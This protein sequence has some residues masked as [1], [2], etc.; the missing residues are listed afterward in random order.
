MHPSPRPVPASSTRARAGTLL[1]AVLTAG[2]L[3]AGCSSST[4][5][6]A[7]SSAGGS[8]G[9][10]PAA[11]SDGSSAAAGQLDANGCITN[12]DPTVDYYPDKSEITYATN[13]TIDYHNSYQVLTV[14]QPTQG[15][16]PVSYVLVR[17]GA[18]TPDLTGELAGDTVVTTPV[19]SLY[20]GSTSHLGSLAALDSLDV[21]TGV[22]SKSL[23]SEKQVLDRVAEPGV[24]EYAAA[25]TVDAEAVVA[26]KPQVVITAGT[27]DP[28]YAA[29]QAAG[30]PV[31]ADAEWLESDPLG[32]AEWVKYFA[33]LTGKEAAAATFFDGVTEAYNALADK[34]SSA[35][36][37]QVV[38]GQPYQGTWFVPG[39]ESFNARLIADAGGT[40]AWASDTSTGSISTDVE[41]VLANSG[42][43]PVWLAST[44]WTTKAEALAEEPRFADFQAFKTGNVWNAAKDVTAT[45]ANNY[46]E[47]GVVRPDLILGDLVAILH[48]DQL[49]GHEF[50]FYLQL[51]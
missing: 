38:P 44:T 48:P 7:A 50:A 5:S 27:D 19:T 35:T 30:I 2:A 34:L 16:T 51:S 22:A 41:T 11:E 12:F 20:S 23:I 33:A 8:A 1:I 17:C 25:G 13:F 14:Q 4:P 31:L 26:G 10:P 43:A 37:V 3:L 15:G 40:T 39:G 24:V 36:P 18:P 49:P 29:I 9:A 46:Y 28:A 45:G 32:R 21:L 42:Q 47:L 6:S